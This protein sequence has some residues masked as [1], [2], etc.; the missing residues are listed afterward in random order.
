MQPHHSS[1]KTTVQIPWKSL[2]LLVPHR[3]R[4]RL[5]SKLRNRQSP[6][7]SLT[8][9]QTSF[10]PAETL[11]ALQAHRWSVHDGQ[12]ILI[13][14]LGIFCLSI[15]ES[16][17][18]IV[19]TA[20]ATLLLTSLL[21]PITRQFFLPFMP[22]AAYLIWFYACRSVITFHAHAKT[23]PLTRQQVHPS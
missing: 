5:R 8:S 18:P 7:S 22:I 15:M 1:T 6:A 3:L 16:P 17:G 2:Q 21:L 13:A 20:V 14:I 11:R 10:S 23:H 12:W 4:R 19:K 9:L